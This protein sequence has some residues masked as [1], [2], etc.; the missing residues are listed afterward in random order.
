MLRLENLC[1]LEYFF[2]LRS[3]EEN[4]V[5]TT[6]LWLCTEIASWKFEIGRAIDL[7]YLA[8]PSS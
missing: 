6:V 5:I 3:A 7:D 4:P 8:D 2:L 1:V